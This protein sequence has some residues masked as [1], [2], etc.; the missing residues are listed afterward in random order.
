[1]VVL[2]HFGRIC[3]PHSDTIQRQVKGY[4][5]F[6]Y[7]QIGLQ[8][9]LSPLNS[10]LPIIYSFF[11][12]YKDGGMRTSFTHPVLPECLNVYVCVYTHTQCLNVYTFPIYNFSFTSYT[13]KKLKNKNKKLFSLSLNTHYVPH[14]LFHLYITEFESKKRRKNTAYGPHY[15]RD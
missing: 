15:H 6:K 13:I 14:V 7:N 11:Q 12:P 10:P 9:F 2:G 5:Y 4:Y 1:M 3:C 8:N